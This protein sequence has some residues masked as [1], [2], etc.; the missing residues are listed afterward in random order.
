MS[1]TPP[2]DI[3]NFLNNLTPTKPNVIIGI[4]DLLDLW[5]DFNWWTDVVQAGTRV[6]IDLANKF[7]NTNFI[8]ITSLEKLEC[9][10]NV[11]NIQIIPWGGDITNQALIY[12]TLSPVLDKNFDSSKTFISL[13]RHPRPHRLVL[14]SYLFGAGYSV[15]GDISYLHQAD[16]DD[17]LARLPWVFDESKHQSIREKILI[18]YSQIYNNKKL[19]TDNFV[20][21]ALTGENNNFDNFN[22]SLRSRYKNSFVELISESSFSAPS[23]MITEKILNSIYGCNFPIIL[24][25]VGCVQHLRDIGFDLFDDIIDHS[26]DLIDNPFDRIIAAVEN[27][28]RL[29]LDSDYVKNVWKINQQ[30]F[31]KNVVVARTVMY[32]WFQNRAILEFN[33]LKLVDNR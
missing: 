11:P 6:L 4:K 17:L 7:P 28:R 10:I 14:L 25:G 26:Y 5:C 21:Y 18:G 23:F 2:S 31:E 12:P 9:E 29:L 19:I 24:S 22:N 27:N 16:Q 20:I 13:N 8:I 3:V 30:R 15:H 1:M 32:E 33:K